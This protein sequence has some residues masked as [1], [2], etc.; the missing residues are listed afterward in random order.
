MNTQTNTPTKKNTQTIRPQTGRPA[1]PTDGA[2]QTL[3]AVVRARPPWPRRPRQPDSRTAG[4]PDN[5]TTGHRQLGVHKS[6]RGTPCWG[7]SVEPPSRWRGQPDSLTSRRPD[8]QATAPKAT[9]T[10]TSSSGTRAGAWQRASGGRERAARPVRIARPLYGP[11][12][13][14]PAPQ[15][16]GGRRWEGGE[17]RRREKE[18]KGK[19]R[20]RIQSDGEAREGKGGRDRT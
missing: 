2:W 10:S 5:W 13:T 14:F 18:E 12:R 16:V 11:F 15:A 19:G 17:G 1:S 6:L 8:G 4:Q 9:S 3:R 20:R 7:F